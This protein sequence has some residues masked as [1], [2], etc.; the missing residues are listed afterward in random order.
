MEKELKLNKKRTIL[1][2][3]GI[4]LV[5]LLLFLSS[6][7]KDQEELSPY[8]SV[9]E[10]NYFTL[11]DSILKKYSIESRNISIA[12]STRSD[13]IAFALFSFND[14]R[15]DYIGNLCY[16]S[17]DDQ[18]QRIFPEQILSLSVQPK[19]D[20]ETPLKVLSS[21]TR[22]DGRDY[23]F[24][25]G[26]I[27]DRNIHDITLQFKDA[28]YEIHSASSTYFSLLREDNPRMKKI[29]GHGSDEKIIFEHF[30]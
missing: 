2:P 27:N 26:W 5:S 29:T 17:F 24:Y 12:S 30:Y 28:S 15:Y 10:H 18:E 22:V 7:L 14:G 13:G 20:R 8:S 6:G 16:K 19:N 21:V 11:K 1:L 9:Y 23:C 25:Y 3:F 4:L